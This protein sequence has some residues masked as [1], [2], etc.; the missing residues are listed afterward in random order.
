[1]Y[2]FLSFVFKMDDAE[3]EDDDH[4]H[5][6]DNDHDHEECSSLHAGLRFHNFE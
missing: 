3:N 2:M 6:H 5:N 1:M 4:V